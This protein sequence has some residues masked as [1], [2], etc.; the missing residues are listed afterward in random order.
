MNLPSHQYYRE[1][2]SG[3]MSAAEQA[4]RLMQLGDI[5]SEY[6]C[7]SNYCAYYHRAMVTVFN[8]E[9]ISTEDVRV[10]LAAKIAWHMLFPSLLPYD[11]NEKRRSFM[12]DL[13]KHLNH[14]NSFNNP[15][16][17]DLAVKIYASYSWGW[18]HRGSFMTYPICTRLRL[19][20][21]IG[22]LSSI[23]RILTR[24]WGGS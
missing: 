20:V 24:Y 16:G 23:Y 10:I 5:K 1:F 14:E 15:F 3:W 8:N 21:F 2:N 9:K 12:I 11:A 18:L 22:R 6:F 19:R 17:K 7:H 13:T 4:E